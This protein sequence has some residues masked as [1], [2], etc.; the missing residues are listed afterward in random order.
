[1]RMISNCATREGHMSV[2]MILSR[3]CTLGIAGISVK[4]ARRLTVKHIQDTVAHFY[5]IPAREMRSARRS[6]SVARPRQIAM[7][8][9]RELTPKSLPDIGGLF[10][11]RDH[12]TV[13]HAIKRIEA[14]SAIDGDI[15]TDVEALRARLVG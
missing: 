12:T 7:Y 5:Q 14:L 11:G 9:T 10:G 4:I 6:R 1:M 2:C 15:A 3:P 8:L 13:M